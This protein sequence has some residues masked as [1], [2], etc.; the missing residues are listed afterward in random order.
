MGFNE[1]S[2]NAHSNLNQPTSDTKSN[3][4]Y[5]HLFTS[6]DS[7][8]QEYRQSLFDIDACRHG[9]VRLLLCFSRTLPNLFIIFFAPKENFSLKATLLT[10]T[11]HTA[12]TNANIDKRECLQE[13]EEEPP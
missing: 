12:P 11:R 4:N 6:L 5:R 9:P 1:Y 3:M 10:H 8:S 7:I 13:S 2:S